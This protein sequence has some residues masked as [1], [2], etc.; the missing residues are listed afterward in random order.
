MPGDREQCLEAGANAYLAKPVSLR[1]L[2][3]TITRCVGA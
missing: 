1:T 2:V 3:A